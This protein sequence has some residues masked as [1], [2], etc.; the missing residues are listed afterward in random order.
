MPIIATTSLKDKLLVSLL[1]RSCH[2]SDYL[3]SYFDKALNSDNN[4]PE[5]FHLRN[6][7]GLFKQQI[8]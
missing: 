8:C 4:F 7:T 3:K 6:M 5:I 1:D 2:R